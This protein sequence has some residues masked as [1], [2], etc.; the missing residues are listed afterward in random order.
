MPNSATITHFKV[1]DQPSPNDPRL[2]GGPDWNANHV[3][4]GLDQ[5]DNTSDV[6]KPVSTAQAAADAV[7][8]ANA[9]TA[10]GAITAQI[11]AANGIATL[12]GTGKLTSS[13]IPAA[14]V[15]ALQYQGTWNASTNTP[16]LASSVGTKGF[17]YKVSVAGTTALNGISSWNVNDVA[18]FDGAT[19]DKIDGQTNEVVSV[20]GRTGAVTLAVADVS[21]AAPL[22]S[23]ALTGTPT[24]PT[25]AALN[26]STQV[27][28]T[29]Y[30]DAAVS[31]LSGTV[32]T[33]LALK[34]PLASPT[35]TGV[36]AAPT[37][38]A[39]NNSTQIATTAYADAATSTLSGTVNTALAL[40]AP[41]AS[42]VFTG[43]ISAAFKGNLLGAAGGTAATGSVATT[44]ANILLYNISSVDWA[45]I[46]TDNNGVM[47]FRT[48]L[49]GTPAPGLYIDTSQIAHFTNSPLLPTAAALDNSTKGATTA[50]ADG[51]VSTLSGTVTASL[52]LK[53]PLASPTFTGTP[54]APTATVGTNTTQIATT[55]FVLANAS[56]A[57][58]ATATPLVDSG[59]GAVGTSLLYARQDHVHPMPAVVAPPTSLNSQSGTTYALVLGDAGK[60][61]TAT[62]VSGLTITIPTNASVA[63]PIGTFIFVTMIASSATVT[64]LPASGAVTLRGTTLLTSGAQQGCTLM[65]V[66]T[67]TWI[68]V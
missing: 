16:A 19:W 29:A 25:A 61:V 9:A 59:S 67:N 41:L 2:I 34:A 23:P 22:A 62:N 20:A 35:L 32:T 54:A 7:V 42:P 64:L 28:S 58:P 47:W 45:G 50:Y 57:T 3:L 4:V 49:T 5:V 21:G 36:P 27:A 56:G 15:G 13:Q 6:N 46:G 40:K 60:E 48:G 33:A 43:A 68:C 10:T 12:D 30:A 65:K 11:G 53:A 31:T 63:F 66:A 26:N 39:L 1:S 55:A 52:A 44:D 37:A 51:A 24:T 8:A 17:Y 18:I 14:L 38:A